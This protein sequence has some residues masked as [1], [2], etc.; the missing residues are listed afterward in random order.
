[1]S[2]D[3][4]IMPTMLGRQTP[5]TRLPIPLSLHPSHQEDYNGFVE[6]LVHSCL[7]VMFDTLS[8]VDFPIAKGEGLY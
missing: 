8:D 1:M 2:S 7:S 3:H 6:K 5:P 4:L